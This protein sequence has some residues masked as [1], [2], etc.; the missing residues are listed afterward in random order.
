MNPASTTT[1][2]LEPEF[3]VTPHA[4]IFKA[5]G[6]SLPL[7]RRLVVINRVNRLLGRFMAERGFNE[8]PAPP[9]AALTGS[10]EAVD[11][12]LPVDH[13]GD[14]A[15]ASQTGQLFLDEMIAR[16]F[17]AVWC[18][19]QS[20]RREWKT[21]ERH[22]TAFQLVE[23]EQEKLDLEGVCG[24]QED[25]LKTV[26]RGLSADMLGGRNVTRLDRMIQCE[27]PR[28]TYREALAILNARGW[29][30]LFGEDLHRDAEATLS[31]YCG[32]LP[33]QVTHFPGDLKFFN[34]KNDPTDH[35]VTESVETILPYAGETM[36]GG[37]RESRPERLRHHLL[38]S[39]MYR[40][41]LD[42]AGRF[43]AAQTG[44]ENQSRLV[45]RYQQNIR[46]AGEDYLALFQ[47]KELVRGGFALGVARILQYF[48]GLESITDAV[49]QPLNR[50]SFGLA[51]RK[52]RA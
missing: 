32:Q 17:P 19:T 3:P 11:T 22:L 33:V 16:G 7:A 46:Q 45:D 13:C 24:L 6:R 44:R 15:F 50:T 2:R 36:D 42:S 34:L 8:V 27:L 49:I 18:Q 38:E 41:L 10:C 52:A 25:L 47:G 40:Q 30:M 43:A 5:P 35:A 51:S 26:A 21:D 39:T 31:R 9:L 48:M 37:V 29:S 4:A 12:S 14:L 1:A 28:L 20:L 23:A